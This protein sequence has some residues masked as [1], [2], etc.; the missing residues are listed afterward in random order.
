[1][2]AL[3]ETSTAYT[4]TED[5]VKASTKVYSTETSTEAFEEVNFPSLKL[6]RMIPGKLLLRKPTFTEASVESSVKAFTEAFTD[7]VMEVKDFHGSFCGSIVASTEAFEEEYRFHR[8]FGGSIFA[9]PEEFTEAFTQ[10]IP[11]L[12]PNPSPFVEAFVEAFVGVTSVE[13]FYRNFQTIVILLQRN[14]L[15]NLTRK[16]SRKL[17]RKLL[18]K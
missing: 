5:S 17:S 14:L 6:L 7:A 4:P 18:W 8:S 12:N 3:T 9:S 10:P 16:R 15:R 13:A 1:M 2:K 11:N